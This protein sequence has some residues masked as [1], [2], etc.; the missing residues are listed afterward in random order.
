MQDYGGRDEVDQAQ[1]AIILAQ[2]P[3]PEGPR[4][5]SP[6]AETFQA[7]FSTPPAQAPQAEATEAETPQ[8]ET[9]DPRSEAPQN[10]YPQSEPLNFQSEAAQSD[11]SRAPQAVAAS[12]LNLQGWAPRMQYWSVS[13]ARRRASYQPP[14]DSQ[15]QLAQIYR[16]GPIYVVPDAAVGRMRRNSSNATL[17]HGHCRNT[18]RPQRRYSDQFPHRPPNMQRTVSG[19]MTTRPNSEPQQGS[20]RPI[21]RSQSVQSHTLVVTRVRQAA[22]VEQAYYSEHPQLPRSTGL[23]EPPRLVLEGGTTQGYF[24]Q[25]TFQLDPE[26]LSP[27]FLT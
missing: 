14:E 11:T 10:E 21:S 13:R 7:E 23:V 5:D 4:A 15:T 6:R 18:A 19:L 3:Q 22:I 25:N 24:Q 8:A 12:R 2:A 16:Y 27:G 26:A 1:T 20:Q 17:T 9:S